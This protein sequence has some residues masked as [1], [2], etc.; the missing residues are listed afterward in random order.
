VHDAWHGSNRSLCTSVIPAQLEDARGGIVLMTGSAGH[1]GEALVRI[2]AALAVH[3]RAK[4]LRAI[5]AGRFVSAV[6]A[7]S[8]ELTTG[9]AARSTIV[10]PPR[11]RGNK[12]RYE[13]V[14]FRAELPWESVC[15]SIL[16]NFDVD[17]ETKRVLRIALER[18]RMSLGLTDGL[19]DG[20]IA[21]QIIEFAKAGERNPDLLCEGALK[22]LR[23]HLFG[24]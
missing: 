1:L 15:M 10:A 13:G 12:W 18:T 14:C 6:L 4:A 9:L 20:I 2:P 22:K 11:G 16:E 17:P 21:N 8:P 5:R 19:A 3:S 7:A 23:E 24:D